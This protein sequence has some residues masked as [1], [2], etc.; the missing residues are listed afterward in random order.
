MT[1]HAP[2]LPS[3]DSFTGD[4]EES[5]CFLLQEEKE[6]LFWTAP[7]IVTGLDQ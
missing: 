3:G 5:E 4:T 7:T 1:L 2:G 6:L